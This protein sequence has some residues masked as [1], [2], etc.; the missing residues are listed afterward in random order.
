MRKP[1]LTLALLL[2]LMMPVQ[3]AHALFG[4]GIVFDPNN[5]AQNLLTASRSLIM[6]RNQVTSLQNEIR[7][8][9]NMSRNLERL[10]L[11]TI[12][13]L[14][15]TLGQMHL[16]LQ[17]AEGVA[18]EVAAIKA[19]Y[20]TLYPEKYNTALSRNQY[21]KDAHARWAQSRSAY[22]DSLKTQAVIIESL[23]EDEQLWETL[24]QSSQSSA[25]ALQAAQ[26]TNQML[27]LQAQQT[28][29][30][31]QL[32]VM[33]YRAEALE[34]ARVLADKEQ[35]RVLQERF[36]GDGKSYHPIPVKIN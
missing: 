34:K 15:M 27:A 31:Q 30:S 8:L 10:G 5:F 36:L 12:P 7:M 24:V 20:K 26:V 25:G 29:K 18:L 13:Q 1:V 14:K 2:S 11:N 9:K 3:Q 19:R 16:A 33:H 6:I 4:F 23:Q 35:A 32:T 21:V 17:N 28:A 22:G